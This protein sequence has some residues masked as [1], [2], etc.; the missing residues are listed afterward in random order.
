VKRG[1]ETYSPSPDRDAVTCAALAFTGTLQRYD[2]RH[3]ETSYIAY[4]RDI[5][6]SVPVRRTPSS[7]R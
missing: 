1:I 4:T 5:Q 3:G 6:E 7:I 2:L